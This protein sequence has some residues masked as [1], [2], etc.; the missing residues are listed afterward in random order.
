MG[1]VAF[2]PGGFYEFSLESGSVKSRDGARV[3]VVSDSVMANLVSA[4][5][6]RGDVTAVRQLGKHLGQSVSRAV[7]GDAAS[8]TPEEVMGYA[9]ATLAL[10]GWG[11]L[12]LERWGDALVAVVK[13]VPTLDADNLGVAALLGEAAGE[14]LHGG[15]IRWGL[16]LK[17]YAAAE[18]GCEEK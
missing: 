2:D 3:V 15:F 14:G 1:N 12:A 8:A 4:A 11:R 18:E 10:F 17:E 9:S 5:V 7:G 13:E 6:E 16:G